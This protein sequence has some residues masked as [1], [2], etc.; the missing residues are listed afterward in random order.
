MKKLML[1][2]LIAGRTNNETTLDQNATTG[3]NSTNNGF[4]H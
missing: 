1:I 3:I 2:K 4:P